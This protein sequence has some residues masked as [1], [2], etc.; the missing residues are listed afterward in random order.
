MKEGEGI[1]EEALQERRREATP[2]VKG[3]QRREEDGKSG[4]VVTVLP[5][6]PF[7]TAFSFGGKPLKK[8]I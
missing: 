7:P 1:L 3:E 8:Y 2:W 5:F 4:P 6:F